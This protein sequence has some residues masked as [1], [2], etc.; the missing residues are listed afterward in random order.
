MSYLRSRRLSP[1]R[2][3]EELLYRGHSVDDL[4]IEIRNPNIWTPCLT[5]T[6]RKHYSGHE[7]YVHLSNGS[8]GNY[9]EYIDKLL[10]KYDSN[11]EILTYIVECIDKGYGFLPHGISIENVTWDDASILIQYRHNDKAV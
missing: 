7:I 10:L 11:R 3:C 6:I 8:K 4:K 5:G 1:M 2:F 9:E